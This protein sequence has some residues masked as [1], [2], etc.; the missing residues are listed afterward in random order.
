MAVVERRWTETG[1]V[2]NTVVRAVAQAEDTDP[3]EL[4]PPMFEIVDLD[5]VERLVASAP[6]EGR[7]E[8][9]VRFRY[10]EYDVTVYSDGCVSVE[11]RAE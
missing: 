5:A 8:G 6:A 7:M 11:E 3:G 4:T 2:G 10:N 9:L 1:S